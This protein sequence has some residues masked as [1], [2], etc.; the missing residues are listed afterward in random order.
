M[1]HMFETLN[2]TIYSFNPQEGVT[3]SVAFEPLVAAMLKGSK[4]TN[5]L[6][7]QSAHGGYIVLI[8]ALW[9]NS[10]VNSDVE[11]KAKEVLSK[12][13]DDALAKGLLQKFQYLNY[14]APYQRPFGSYGGDELEFLKSVSKKYDPAQILQKKVGGF[15]L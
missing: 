4:H 2:K 11:A 10:A 5:V 1:Q 8:S 13:E 15:K 3:W 6:G 12:W 14:A 9:P 7:L